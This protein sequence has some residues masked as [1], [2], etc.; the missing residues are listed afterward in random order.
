MVSVSQMWRRCLRGVKEFAQGHTVSHWHSQIH[1][2]S[3]C[4]LF[5]FLAGIGKLFLKGPKSKYFR[6]AGLMD[7][8]C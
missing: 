2:T 8:L 6:F 4:I 3:A 7:G 5:L 1:L